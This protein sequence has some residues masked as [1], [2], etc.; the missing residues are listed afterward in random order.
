[1]K[2]ISELAIQEEEELRVAVAM[3]FQAKN[4]LARRSGFSPAQVVLGRD[5]AAAGGVVAQLASGRAAHGLNQ[6][7]VYGEQ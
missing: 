7:V 5:P 2:V 3:V 1:M 6:A 4:R